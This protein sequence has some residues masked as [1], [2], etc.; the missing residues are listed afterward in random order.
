MMEE[1]KLANT[2]VHI[3]YDQKP[4]PYHRVVADLV[5]RHCKKDAVMLDIGV[6]VGHCLVLVQNKRPDINLVGA[7][8]DENCLAITGSRVKLDQKLLIGDVEDLFDGMPKYDCVVMSHSLEHML[9]PARVVREV[10]KI[11]RPGGVL[12]LAVPNPMRP[13]VMVN[14]LL[15]RKRVNLGHVYAWD[16]S[17]WM[18]FIEVILGLNVIEYAE[19]YFQFPFQLSVRL[20]FL[21]PLE[22]FLVR[23]F[24]WFA[25][26]NIVAIRQTN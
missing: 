24:P 25:M 21:R 22:L 6:G 18:N 1:N 3:P 7:D 15:R 11:I 26:S 16:R 19:D 14:N 12:V 5:S 9:E 20:P 8:I 17:H 4:Q 13:S 10:M 23:F 2:S